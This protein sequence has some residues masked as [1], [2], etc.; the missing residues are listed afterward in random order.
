MA[1]TAHPCA[2]GTLNAPATWQAV[3]LISDLHLQ[4]SAPATFEAWRAHMRATPADA[5]LMLGDVFEVW[6][7]DDA[8]ASDPFLQACAQVLREASARMAVGFMPGNRDF[9]V[10]PRFLQDCGLTALQDPTLLIWGT[11]RVLLSHGDALCLDDQAYQR[12]RAVSRTDAWQNEFLARPLAERL[13]LA[14][15]MRAQSEAHNQS[16]AYFADADADLTRDWLHAC[17]ALHLVHGHTHRPADHAV[18]GLPT[19][20]RQVLS[21]WHA[22]GQAL[23][24]E[25]LRLHADGR[26]TR[27]HPEPA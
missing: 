12:F 13:A 9:L 21:D 19:A 1:S 25:V 2:F 10:G 3:D 6:V 27:L 20:T 26:R 11:Q 24:A 8:V 16:V 23:R 14:Q 7:G 17:G 15:S 5:V 22:D 18:A 4:A